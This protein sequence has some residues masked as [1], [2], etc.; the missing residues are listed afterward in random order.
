V[1][2]LSGAS[3][4]ALSVAWLDLDAWR[5][6]LHALPRFSALIREGGYLPF[7]VTPSGMLE[8]AGVSP[9]VMLAGRIAFATLGAVIVW[10]TFRSAASPSQ[11]LAALVGASLL[12]VP[13]AM[14]YDLAALAPAVAV[15]ASEC[16]SEG[17]LLALVAMLPLGLFGA[18]AL[19]TLG[20]PLLLVL[21]PW[22]RRRDTP[23][24]SRE[25]PAVQAVVVSTR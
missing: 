24:N 15:A 17:W 1:A 22:K 3:L 16:E 4:A 10:G 19:V 21:A 2:L 23:D 11:R 9:M 14:E 20:V 13:Y 8:R 18:P 6:W 7:V 12:A 25:R 5:A